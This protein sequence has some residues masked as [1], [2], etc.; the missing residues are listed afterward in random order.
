M[1]DLPQLPATFRAYVVDKPADGAF[2]RGLR[3]F[4]TADLPPGEV[5]VRVEWSSVNFKDGLAAREDGRVARSYPLIPGIDLAGVVVASEDD[6]IQVGTRV[7]ANGYDIGTARHGGFGELARIPA[8]WTVPLPDGLSTRDAMEIGTAG[9]TAAM[10]VDA[11]ERAGVAPGS[12]PV[13]VT[14]AAGGVGSMAIAILAARGHEVWAA[15]GKEDELD[16]LRG[17][18]ATG[19]LT[20]DEVTAPGRPLDSARWAGAVDTAGAATL[21]YVL[22]TLRI[23]GAVASSGNASGAELATTVFPFILRGVSLLGM[24]SANMAIEPRR[25]LWARLADDLQAARHRRL[26]HRGRPRHAGA[27]ARRDRR[28]RGT[29]PLGGPRHGLGRPAAYSPSSPRSWATARSTGSSAASAG[30]GT[31]GST[32][33]TDALAG[34]D[35]TGGV[36]D[37]PEPDEL[38]LHERSAR[39]VAMTR[40]DDRPLPGEREQ[41]LG[42]RGPVHRIAVAEEGRRA[43]LEQVAGAQDVGAIDPEDDVVVRVAAPEIPELDLALVVEAD[44]RHLSERAL[45]R[46]QDDLRELRRDLGDLRRRPSALPIAGATDHL[47]GSLVAPDRRRAEDAVAEGVVVVPVAVHDDPHGRRPE[48]AQVVEDLARLARRR[49]GVEHERLLAPEHDHDVLVEE[50]VSAHEDPFSDLRPARR[51]AAILRRAPARDRLRSRAWTPS[52]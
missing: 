29:R 20:R 43:V 6:A 21:P 26:H 10:S 3:E 44:R 39:V 7:V 31:S 9:F 41:R 45:G 35:A 15:T 16:R 4:E 51:H 25:A 38:R 36:A 42:G 2:S 5:T 8:D 18:G 49:A 34:D 37:R 19:F 33:S 28:G 46:V 40:D 22:R 1:P 12:G 17:L 27:G 47:R 50:R 14:G 52:S 13:L 11:L 32:S 24:D 48:L 30:Y 23:G